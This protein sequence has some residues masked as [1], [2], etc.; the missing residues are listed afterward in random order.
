MAEYSR[1]CYKPRKKERRNG[2]YIMIRIV[3]MLTS[4]HLLERLS[5]RFQK[6]TIFFLLCGRGAMRVL[7][8]RLL[9]P[10]T[11]ESRAYQRRP[12]TRRCSPTRPFA[13]SARVCLHRR[14][15]AGGNKVDAP[16]R[17]CGASP[18]MQLVSLFVFFLARFQ[19]N[20]SVFRCF[21]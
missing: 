13:S 11:T 14:C 10:Q 15:G 19:I 21:V 4:I 18:H 5:E 6:K 3:R 12:S 17:I 2:R 8:L 20:V 7:P 16:F 1:D 9:C